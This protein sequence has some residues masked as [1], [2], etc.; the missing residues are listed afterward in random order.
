MKDY[1]KLDLEEL[2]I[3]DYEILIVA[4]NIVELYHLEITEDYYN[5]LISK[6]ERNRDKLEYNNKIQYKEF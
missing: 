2:E 6:L 5:E 1:R 3:V 4:L